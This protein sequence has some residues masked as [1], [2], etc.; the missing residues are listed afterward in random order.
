MSKKPR[1]S[2]VQKQAILADLDGGQSA[3]DIAKNHKV[4]KASVYGIRRDRAKRPSSTKAILQDRITVAESRIAQ[5]KRYQDEIDSLQA[6]IHV[7]KTAL[8]S[9]EELESRVSD[10]GDKK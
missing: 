7:M 5:L 8:R 2:D 4:S 3:T 9:L 6:E 1:L 10:E